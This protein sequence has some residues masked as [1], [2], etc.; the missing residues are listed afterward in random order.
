MPYQALRELS[1]ITGLQVE[2]SGSVA[3]TGADPVYRTRYQ[4]GTAA[5]ASLAAVGVAAS[6]LWMLRTGRRQTVSVDIRAAAA[7]LRFVRYVSIN[8]QRARDPTGPI[9]GFHAARNGRWVFIHGSYKHLADRAAGI[10]GVPAEKAEVRRAVQ[11][12]DGEALE[13]AVLAAGGC[14]TLTR[15]PEEWQ[16]HPQHAAVASVPVVHISKIGNAPPEALR[17][18]A[19]PLSGA[20]V[21]DVTRVIAGPTC[22]RT[23]AEHGAEV[24]KV[25]REDL[26]NS[27]SSE[28]ASGL[29]KRSTYLDL[30]DA[31]QADILRGLVRSGDVFAQSY[32]PGALA[33]L[34]FSPSDVAKIRPG[35]VYVTLSAWG[36]GGPFS[37]YRGY[38]SIVSNANGMTLMSGA[39]GIPHEFPT[40]ALDYIAGYL[41]AFGAMVAL[42][43]RAREGGSWLVET[44]LAAV[45]DWIIKRG[46]LSGDQLVAVK[47]P[48]PEEIARLSMETETGDGRMRHLAPIVK[49]SETPPHWERPPSALGA[50]L[51]EWLPR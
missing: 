51:P 14:A 5:A 12:W 20:R 41:M 36:P 48:T 17:E 32:R 38:D 23:L 47:E 11:S 7:S 6:D 24:L 3:I 27:G 25:S 45:G 21:V 44:S 1:D 8:G 19:R 35:I 49:M 30:R 16:A 39:D 50:D 46:L 31:R 13:K 10:L 33:S 2:G 37:Q 9:S 18:G 34:G 40:R 22:G 15:T 4:V 29:G 43:R 42:G 26:P 28:L